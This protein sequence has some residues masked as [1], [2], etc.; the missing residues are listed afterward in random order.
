MA[1]ITKR[2]WVSERPYI[3]PGHVTQWEQS[4]GDCSHP[5]VKK[6]LLHHWRHTKNRSRLRWLFLS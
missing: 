1:C 3:P 2:E 6:P 5:R 4:Q